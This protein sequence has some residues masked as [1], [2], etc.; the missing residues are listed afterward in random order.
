MGFDWEGLLGED[1]YDYVCKHGLDCYDDFG[2][3]QSYNSSYNSSYSYINNKANNT[4]NK[5]NNTVVKLSEDDDY[6]GLEC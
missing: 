2:Y 4:N 6:E 5:T 1:G 3:F